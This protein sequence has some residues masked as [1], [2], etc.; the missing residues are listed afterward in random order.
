MKLKEYHGIENND[1]DY[2]KDLFHF[3]RLKLSYFH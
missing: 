1:F 3:N 2:L